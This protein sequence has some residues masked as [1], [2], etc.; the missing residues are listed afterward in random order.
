MPLVEDCWA[1][2]RGAQWE[3]LQNAQQTLEAEWAEWK[4]RDDPIWALQ[5]TLQQHAVAA[6]DQYE[7]QRERMRQY[8][9][10][11]AA[12]P[13]PYPHQSP[14]E[15]ADWVAQKS[16]VLQRAVARVTADQPALERTEFYIEPQS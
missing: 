6:V 15:L 4:H 2:A 14:R 7:K 5:R 9:Q 10:D 8:R 12:Q 16:C 1:G 3:R 13:W 11:R